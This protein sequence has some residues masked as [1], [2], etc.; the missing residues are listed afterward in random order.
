MI[1]VFSGFI[2]ADDPY[3]RSIG[4]GLAIGVAFDAFLVRMLLVPALVHLLGPAAWYMPKWLNRT[5]PDVDVEGA[6]L[7]EIAPSERSEERRV[8]KE[9]GTGCTMHI[10]AIIL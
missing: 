8:G 5:L 9:C 4:F 1:S 2:Y 10:C 7:A 3:I 6:K